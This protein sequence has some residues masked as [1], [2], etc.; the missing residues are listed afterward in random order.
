MAGVRGRG[1]RVGE[2]NT[3]IHRNRPEFPFGSVL[4]AKGAPA[5]VA[6][7]KHGAVAALTRSFF[8]PVGAASEACRR[9][10]G[11]ALAQQLVQRHDGKIDVALGVGPA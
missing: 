11:V 8:S 10:W 3:R 2:K 4:G 5:E 6:D 9:V 1:V 7:E